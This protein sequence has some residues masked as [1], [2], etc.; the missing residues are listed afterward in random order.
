M[1]KLGVM[2]A[3]LLFAPMLS[4]QYQECERCETGWAESVWPTPPGLEGICT[5]PFAVDYRNATCEDAPAALSSY[6][7]CAVWKYSDCGHSNP[8]IGDDGPHMLGQCHVRMTSLDEHCHAEGPC[9]TNE[10]PCCSPV[11]TRL[12]PTEPFKFTGPNDPVLFD[13]EGHGTAALF[14]WTKRD[15]NIALLAIDLDE[16]G[17]I[18]S[19][20]ELFGDY[21]ADGPRRE[22]VNGFVRMSWL[23]ANED[24]LLDAADPWWGRLLFWRDFNHDGISQASELVRVSG[25]ARVKPNGDTVK[26]AAFEVTYRTTEREDRYGNA[27]RFQ[28]KIWWSDGT[29]DKTFDMYFAKVQ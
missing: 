21:T 24:G 16:N 14:T 25:F 19:G 22:D 27:F 26:V 6:E 15:S 20:R 11:V 23:D 8:F 9:Q 28:S 29:H 12:D 7:S 2:F 4:A 5:G 17:V 18:D 13:L 10:P 3:A 1:R